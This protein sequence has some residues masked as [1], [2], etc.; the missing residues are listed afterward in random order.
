[1]KLPPLNALRAFESAART[2]SFT[3][4]A[5]ELGVTSAAVSQQIRKLEVYVGR[6][7]FLRNNNQL[8]LTDAGRDL[9]MNAAAA[10]L[11]IS[12]FTSDMVKPRPQKPTVISAPQSLVER[13]LPDILA[14]MPDMS[15]DVRTEED[16]V[17]LMAHGIDVRIAYSTNGYVDFWTRK[18]FTDRAAPLAAPEVAADWDASIP[19]FE[20]QRL[21]HVDWGPTFSR[22]PKWEDWCAARAVVFPQVPSLTVSS[23]SAALSAAAAGSGIALGQLELAKSEIAAGRLVQL[24]N[25]SIPL[26][27]PYVAIV[28]NSRL[29]ARRVQHVLEA[30]LPEN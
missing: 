29:S 15:F 20:N 3:D 8:L 6:K 24:S 2:N 23:G 18:L 26:F 9:Y 12:S 11:Q 25:V 30:L 1:M 17:D 19:D 14:R 13:W 4:A 5:Q 21:I 10:L 28:A 22:G 16:P 27:Q 7:L